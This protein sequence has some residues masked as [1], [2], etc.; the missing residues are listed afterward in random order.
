MKVTYKNIKLHN[1]EGEVTEIIDSDWVKVK[2]LKPYVLE[3][4][5][6]VNSL[7]C[8]DD[9]TPLSEKLLKEK[10]DG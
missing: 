3:V 6:W 9:S 1:Y 4:K 2:W 8:I 7:I 5:E 10:I